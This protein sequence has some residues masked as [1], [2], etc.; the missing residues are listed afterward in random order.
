MGLKSDGTVRAVGLNKDGQLDVDIWKDIK[1]IAAGSNHTIGLKSD[2]TL[3]AAGRN[4]YGQCDVSAWCDI[5]AVAAGNAHTLDSVPMARYLL[6]VI[7]SMDNAIQ[8][9][10]VASNR[11][12]NYSRIYD[13][14]FYDILTNRIIE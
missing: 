6:L 4:E 8:V 9:N 11:L 14:K 2:G 7:I 13:L 1:A 12:S 5:V 10:G 3:E